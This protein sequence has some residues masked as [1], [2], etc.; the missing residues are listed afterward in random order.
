MYEPLDDLP[1]LLLHS[2]YVLLVQLQSIL[3]VRFSVYNLP[4]L[5]GITPDFSRLCRAVVC[6]CI[7][8]PVCG[9]PHPA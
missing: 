5:M 2:R 1:L 8:P 7:L 4:R 6:R 9:C 3:N